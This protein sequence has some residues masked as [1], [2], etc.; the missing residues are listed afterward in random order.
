MKTYL[1]TALKTI[2]A[3]HY[4]G[5]DIKAVHVGAHLLWSKDAEPRVNLFDFTKATMG[6][7]ITTSGEIRSSSYSISDFIEV[8][9]STDYTYSSNVT[10]RDAFI[11]TAFYDVN[12]VFIRR[13]NTL[14]RSFPYFVNMRPPANARYVRLNINGA[15][16][17]ENRMFNLGL[18]PLEYQ[19]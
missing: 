13:I 4:T 14:N 19:P 15:P 16:N 2:Q 10:G 9:P 11:H 5:Y 6:F 8:T 3:G 18:V 17:E 7:A 1:S 12:K